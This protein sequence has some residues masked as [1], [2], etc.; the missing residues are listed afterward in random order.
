MFS[1]DLMKMFLQSLFKEAKEELFREG[2]LV[3]EDGVILSSETIKLVNEIEETQLQMAID[4]AL[5]ERDEVTFR[6]LVAQCK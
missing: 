2:R 6:K 5:D 1:D 3:N 4:K